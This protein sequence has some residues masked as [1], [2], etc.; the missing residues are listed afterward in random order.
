MKNN[1]IPISY[2]Q[3]IIQ[4]L[5]ECKYDEETPKNEEFKNILYCNARINALE[6]LIKYW[7]E[8]KDDYEVC[9]DR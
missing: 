2:I 5:N 9:N 8:D 3:E 1:N 6:D 4:S 7:N